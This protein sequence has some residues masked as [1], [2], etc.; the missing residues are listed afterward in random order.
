MNKQ[1]NANSE[2][3]LDELVTRVARKAGCVGRDQQSYYEQL[4][5]KL[6]ETKTKAENKLHKVKIKL[7]MAKTM[8][9]FAEEIRGY[10]KDGLLDLIAEGHTE[11][12]ALALT[13]D[14]FNQ[15]EMDSDFDGLMRAYNQFGLEEETMH[16]RQN[17]PYDAIGVFY[18]AYF[19]LG[20]T[21]GGLLGW[22]LGNGWA[23]I[24]GGI[25]VGLGFGLG[26]GVLTMAILMLR[27]HR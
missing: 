18:G 15:T 7:G 25:A 10:L 4:Q 12:Q 5:Q 3:Q 2:K 27:G 26:L 20:I 17:V 19:I 13:L 1:L 23:D 14:K 6:T 8:P 11:E 24:I 9:D 21:T 22:L 16:Q